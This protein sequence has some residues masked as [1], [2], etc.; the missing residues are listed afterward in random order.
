MTDLPDELIPLKRF[1]GHLGP[2]VV[3]GYRMGKLVRGRFGHKLQAVVFTGK[4]PPMSCLIDGVQ[5]S[6]W[7]T[8]GKNNIS[9]VDGHTPV[10]HFIDASK[11]IE[12]RLIES[13]RAHID[14]TMTKDNEERLS[15]EIFEADEQDIFVV[16]EVGSGFPE[17]VVK[18]Q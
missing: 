8:M 14:A 18:L 6:T 9:V 15:M 10:A 1:H 5:F 17:R 3:I 16:T 4:H 2:Y 13:V 11:T 12:V 7:C